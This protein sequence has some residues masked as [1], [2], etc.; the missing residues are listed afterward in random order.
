MERTPLYFAAFGGHSEVVK[1]LL[2]KGAD[3][4]K[5]EKVNYMRQT[6]HHH[7]CYSHVSVI[8]VVIHIVQ[9][10]KH[11]LFRLMESYLR[12]V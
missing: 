7:S 5:A 4:E 12:Y 11:Q 9:I 3:I 1:L 2:K 6:L 8:I 10:I